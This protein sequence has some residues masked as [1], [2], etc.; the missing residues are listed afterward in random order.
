MGLVQ[1]CFKDG[2]EKTCKN[3]PHLDP[4]Q[5]AKERQADQKRRN[6][7]PWIENVMT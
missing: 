7:E 2:Q 1:T 4:V 3:I 5:M 6:E